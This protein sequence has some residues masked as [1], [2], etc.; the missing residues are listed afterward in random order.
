MV[1]FHSKLLSYQRLTWHHAQPAAGKSPA[2]ETWS[3]QHGASWSGWNRGPNCGLNH[4]LSYVD[5]V[6]IM[7]YPVLIMVYPILIMVYPML[8]MVYP[9]FVLYTTGPIT[10]FKRHFWWNW[11]VAPSREERNLGCHMGNKVFII[12]RYPKCSWSLYLAIWT[13]R[14]HE[15]T[16]QKIPG[17]T[18]M[19]QNPGTTG[20]DILW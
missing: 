15:A 5:P 13:L 17:D 18:R 8:I 9:W 7:V 6:L 4:G 16:G 1:I 2:P 11:F 19:S 14:I 20:S 10:H 3:Q 12:P